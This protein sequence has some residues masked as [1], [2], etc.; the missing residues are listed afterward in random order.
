MS[1]RA[2]GLAQRVAQGHQ[3]VISFIKECSEAEWN[4]ICPKENWSVGV[5]IHHVASVLPVEI[6]LTKILASGQPITGVTMTEVNENNAEHAEEYVHCSK[7]ETLEL[8][9]RNSAMAVETIQKLSDEELD[10]TAAVSLHWNAP[11][12]TQ[13][14]IEDHPLSHSYHHMTNIRAALGIHSS[15]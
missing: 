11:L 15:S 10:N 13:Y 8:L 9:E 6:E 1:I 2:Q 7:V 4:T 3:E 5:V 14:F 12:T